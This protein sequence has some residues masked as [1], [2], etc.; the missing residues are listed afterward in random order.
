MS[1]DEETVVEPG[2]SGSVDHMKGKKTD[3]EDVDAW[4]RF[5]V[6]LRT[7]GDGK[8]STC[9]A[10]CRSISIESLKVAVDLTP[11]TGARATGLGHGAL[12]SAWLTH[13][14]QTAVIDADVHEPGTNIGLELVVLVGGE[15]LAGSQQRRFAQMS[16]RLGRA[17]KPARCGCVDASFRTELFDS[18]HLNHAIRF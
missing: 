11:E 4:T 13:Q 16:L 18:S 10:R 1:L 5:K 7:T 14:N 17:R 8:S 9:T 12:G 15:V 3:G 6:C 2:S